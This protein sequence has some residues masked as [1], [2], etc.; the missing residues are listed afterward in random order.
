MG[1]RLPAWLLGV[2]FA[3]GGGFHAKAG[4]TGTVDLGVSIHE[5]SLLPLINQAMTYSITVTNR[6]PET[7]T[8]V[9]LVNHLPSGALF[10][11]STL[12]VGTKTVAGGDVMW[13][14]GSLAAGQSVSAQIQVT[15]PLLGAAVDQ[16]E[17]TCLQTDS[18][19]SDNSATSTVTTLLG[20]LPQILSQPQ[21]KQ[22]LPGLPVSIDVAATSDL[23]VRYQWRRNGVN[24]PGETNSTLSIPSF[25]TELGGSY[26]VQVINDLGVVSSQPAQLSPV[27]SVG[28]PFVDNF[29]DS[30]VVTGLT[31][32]GLGENLNATV[33]TGEPQHGGK[34]VGKT[35]WLTWRPLLGGIA[36]IRTTGSTFDT[37]LAVYTGDSLTTLV[38]LVSDDDGGGFR[39]SLVTFNAVAGRD[40]HIAVV[41][42]DGASGLIAMTLGC[43][44]TGDKVP[45]ITTQP[46]GQTVP[47]G[48]S[49]N[50][51]VAATGSGLTYQWLRDGVAV[52]GAD[53]PQFQ[54]ASVGVE[55][56]GVYQVKITSGKR[57]VISDK[58]SVQL[59][60]PG[61]GEPF[62]DVRAEDK[63]TDLL[64]SLLGS[65]LP[66]DGL[67]WSDP[68]QT[69][70]AAS[71]QK[72][73]K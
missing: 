15:L 64:R 70:V 25:Q 3:F 65:I 10:L 61:P 62:Q 12:D 31:V 11:G 47:Q 44:I 57:S 8:G 13:T 45:S 4:G 7:A 34:V 59:F 26:T 66:L 36:T 58:A 52:P 41:G 40:Y 71:S 24:I 27:L 51:S 9:E 42:Y 21:S 50:L 19:S 69:T 53:G 43:E 14:I 6:G 37:V 1:M 2:C 68:K 33:E 73:T 48:G 56:V 28:L 30:H 39:S 54:I 17:V 5:S 49:V 23:P 46:V 72:S 55:Q 16:A 20:G 18:N 29:A 67:I 22:V 38:P 32:I 60:I 63:L 35:V